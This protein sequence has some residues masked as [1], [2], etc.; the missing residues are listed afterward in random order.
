MKYIIVVA[1]SFEE[2]QTMVQDEIDVGW[3]P[4]G[5]IAI[6]PEKI[7]LRHAPTFI[8]YQAMTLEQ[9]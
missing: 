2:L 8:Y 6:E 7:I 4:I 5:G 3:R 1:N 9:Y